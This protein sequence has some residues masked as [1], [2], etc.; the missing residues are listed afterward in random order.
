MLSFHCWSFSAY[1]VQKNV[2]EV[3]FLVVIDEVEHQ[4]NIHSHLTNSTYS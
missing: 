1:K 4:N 2:R 3:I